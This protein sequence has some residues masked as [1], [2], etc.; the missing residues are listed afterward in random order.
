MIVLGSSVTGFV[1]NTII[2]RQ[3]EIAVRPDHADKADSLDHG[4]MLAG[5]VMTDELDFLGI[6]LVKRGIVDY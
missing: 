3:H 4:M 6:R 5:P 1:V 2:N